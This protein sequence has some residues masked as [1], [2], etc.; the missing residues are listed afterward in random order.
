LSCWWVTLRNVR[1]DNI[2]H[3]PLVILILLLRCVQ[4][5]GYLFHCVWLS[6]VVWVALGFAWR[7]LSDILYSIFWK[8]GCLST[9]S[10]LLIM[11]LIFLCRPNWI[12]CTTSRSLALLC[13]F[14]VIQYFFDHSP[15]HSLKLHHLTYS[16]T[17]LDKH[18][19]NPIMKSSNH[20]SVKC[21]K[22]FAWEESYS[23]TKQVTRVFKLRVD[24]K[25]WVDNF[26]APAVLKSQV[27]GEAH[28][29]FCQQ[30]H[31]CRQ[32]NLH[33]W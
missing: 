25:S 21:P 2:G 26:A 23:P 16:Y 15:T 17:L 9:W 1:Y 27:N 11:A 3:V 29:A 19:P 28:T 6:P 22:V 10:H 32:L 7:L 30:I 13:K 31:H 20:D 33:I 24:V 14:L 8:H 12:E 18:S 4:M 5:F